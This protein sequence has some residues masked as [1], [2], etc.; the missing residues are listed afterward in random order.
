MKKLLVVLLVSV[1]LAGCNSEQANQ[2]DNGVSLEIRNVDVL[3]DNDRTALTAEVKAS[4]KKIFYRIEQGESDLLK[5]QQIDLES[6]EWAKIEIEEK[7]PDESLDKEDPPI[8]VIY[9]KDNN[10]QTVNP[11]YIPIDIGME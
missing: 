4:A 6:A 10:G 3:V 2:P 7:L 8:I 1:L 5:E 9:G 11:N